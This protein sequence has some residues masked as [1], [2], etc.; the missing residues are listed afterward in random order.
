MFYQLES[1]DLSKEVK[2]QCMYHWPIFQ[3]YKIEERKVCLGSVEAVKPNFQAWP[4]YCF[5]E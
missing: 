1:S 2:S 3:N 5:S 4:F